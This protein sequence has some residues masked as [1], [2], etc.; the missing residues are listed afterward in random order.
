MPTFE[1][2]P[3]LTQGAGQPVLG[4]ATVTFNTQD[5]QGN[6]IEVTYDGAS[7]SSIVTDGRSTLIFSH[8]T[9][10]AVRLVAPGY[11]ISRVFRAIDSGGSVDGDIDG[12]TL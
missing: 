7:T 5:V 11:G 6:P 2:V 8:P 12:G 3:V 10:T 4:G 1:V 9:L